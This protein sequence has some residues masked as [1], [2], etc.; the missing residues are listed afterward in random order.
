MIISSEITEN[1]EKGNG[2]HLLLGAYMKSWLSRNISYF[3][4][5]NSVFV[6]T[7]FVQVHGMDEPPIVLFNGEAWRITLIQAADLINRSSI[8][9]FS[10]VSKSCNKLVFETMRFR[11][12]FNEDYRALVLQ[13]AEYRKWYMRQQSDLSNISDL[14]WN[15][16]GTVCAKAS[17]GQ[18][19]SCSLSQRTKS[20]IVCSRINQV[21][22]ERRSLLS[23]SSECDHKIWPYFYKV[24]PHKPRICFD[25]VRN[26]YFHA[27]GGGVESNSDSKAHVVE[28]QLLSE[29]TI[30]PDLFI[31]MTKIHDKYFTL[32]MFLEFPLLLEA[33]LKSS[34][35]KYTYGIQYKIFMLEGVTIPENYQMYQQ[36]HTNEY[37][38]SYKDLPK[39]VRK[40]VDARYKS[41]KEGVTGEQSQAKK[42]KK[43]WIIF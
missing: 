13:D 6:C 19:L 28:Y 31:C 40:A 37:Y 36:Y 15:E 35:T 14:V 41:Q 39:E 38:K 20:K 42:K 26:V 9:A 27:Y 18:K 2:E 34:I 33:F 29:A 21:L 24:L 8:R 17:Y 3:C 25:G 7:L 32:T 10:E 22:I 11:K 5:T 12:Q 1:R 23:S 30:K 4:S 43:K 16:N